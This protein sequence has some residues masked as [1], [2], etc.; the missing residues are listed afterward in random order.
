MT[1]DAATSRPDGTFTAAT[2]VTRTGAGTW[3]GTVQPGW[4]IAGNANGGYLLAM[5]AR[6]L[7]EA[8]GRPDPVT[9]TAHFLSP[10]RPGP[11]AIAADVHKTGR[12]FVDV[13]AVV[14]ADGTAP[15]DRTR[16][17]RRPRHATWTT[18]S[19]TAH[20]PNSPPPDACVPAGGTGPAPRS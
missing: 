7:V 3:R 2:A 4:D 13:S 10:G 15:P 8:T 17:V 19:S 1:T 6:A 12:R 20:P 16:L 14:Q 5:T 9:V 18:C 11:V